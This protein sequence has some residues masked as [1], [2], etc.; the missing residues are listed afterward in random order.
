MIANAS[1]TGLY[2]SQELLW[3]EQRILPK[4]SFHTTD[5]AAIRPNTLGSSWNEQ[6]LKDYNG[7]T[8]W[9]SFNLHSFTKLNV[10][11]KWFNF[12]LGY[13]ADGV[14]FGNDE[15]DTTKLGNLHK[16]TRQFYFS[17]DVD[18]TRIKT[19]STILKTFFSVF[20]TIKI[21]SPTLELNQ[22]GD[23][24]GYFIYF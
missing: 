3:K 11:P 16:R 21:P 22:F 20:N 6:L 8:Y 12:A 17:F 7:Q 15:N 5:F 24:K 14:L 1:G 10:F 23:V 2:V 18:L 13:G 19:N 4:F 9:L